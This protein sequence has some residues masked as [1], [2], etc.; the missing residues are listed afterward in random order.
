M[1]RSEHESEAERSRYQHR[2]QQLEER[3]SAETKK[4]EEVVHQYRR[5]LEETEAF[6]LLKERKYGEELHKVQEQLKG[7]KAKFQRAV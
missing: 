4:H 2:L 6:A 5:K 1:N 7:A 3:A